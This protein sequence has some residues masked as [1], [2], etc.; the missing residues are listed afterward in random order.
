MRPLLSHL[1]A[2]CSIRKGA[3]FTLVLLQ[4]LISLFTLSLSQI[5][6]MGIDALEFSDP[7]LLQTVGLLALVSTGLLVLFSAGYKLFLVRLQNHGQLTLQAALM[8]TL[9]STKKRQLD[10]MSAGGVLTLIVNNAANSVSRSL[11]ALEGRCNGVCTIVLG[12]VYMLVLEWRL[13]GIL[14]LYT[15]GLHLVVRRFK[16]TQKAFSRA[17]VSAEKE[18]SSFLV[19]LLTN[20]MS[21]KIFEK[22]EFFGAMHRRLERALLVA[23]MKR[24]T[25]MNAIADGMWGMVKLSE[26][27]LIYGL[28]AYFIYRGFTTAGTLIAFTFAI[29][30]VMKG[31]D[32]LLFS[33]GDAAQAAAL[34]ESV[35]TLLHTPHRE[36][37]PKG[38]LPQEPFS[39]RAENLSF[40]YTEELILENVS[41]TIKPGE[42]I[43]LQGPNGKGKTT[44]LKLLSG[45]YRPTAGTLY[46]GEQDAGALHINS[47]SQAYSYISQDSNI[48]AGSVRENLALSSDYDRPRAEQILADLGLSAAAENS[49]FS[50]SQG[51][52]QRVNIGRALYRG[53]R[54]LIIGDEIF[55]NIDV[56]KAREILA[57]LREQFSQSTMILISHDPL[58]LPFDQVWTVAD[59]TVLQEVC[60]G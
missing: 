22:N 60:A 43:L 12:S 4:L 28:G 7:A 53:A 20:M 9:V 45:L 38:A 49:P 21:V 16:K 23:N 14:L 37:E 55:A 11:S 15:V 57:L 41:F 33:Q 40:G 47:L 26:F 30:L 6:K 8:D 3:V 5:L 59:K 52:K 19:D 34:I 39:V 27:L 36:D 29:D 13:G 48:L 44:L 31:L 1:S 51:E 50:L 10:S 56:A 54:P 32:A 58:D 42:K 46:F 35:N 25:L 2:A 18:T 24:N 17:A